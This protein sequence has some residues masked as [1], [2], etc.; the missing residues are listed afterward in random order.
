MDFNRFVKAE[1]SYQYIS[2]MRPVFNRKALFT[3]TTGNYISPAE[4]SAYGFFNDVQN[5]DIAE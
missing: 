5:W 2:S 4:P 3:D 1:Q